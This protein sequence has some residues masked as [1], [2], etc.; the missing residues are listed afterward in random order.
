MSKR[1]WAISLCLT[2]I[3]VLLLLA[4]SLNAWRFE[5]A[6]RNASIVDSPEPIVLPGISIPEDTPVW[7]ILLFWLAL[8]VT[9]VLFFLFLPTNARI[10]CVPIRPSRTRVYAG[11]IPARGGVWRSLEFGRMRRV[12]RHGA[13]TG[14]SWFATL[15]RAGSGG[16]NARFRWDV[17]GG[18]ESR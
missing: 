13:S 10:K 18:P 7:T 2:V 4:P 5:P 14:T 15:W 12:M 11:T 9:L 6:P 3:G 16:W 1:W 17:F 8:V